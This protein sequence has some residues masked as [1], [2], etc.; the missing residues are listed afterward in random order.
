MVDAL[1]T[2]EDGIRGIGRR[3]FEDVVGEEELT[4]ADTAQLLFRRLK[5]GEV[6]E[7]RALSMGR[8]QAGYFDDPAKFADAARAVDG[9]ADVYM[10]IN[11]VHGEL[12]AR[13]N[14]R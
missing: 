14:N 10:T 11:P 2:R 7:V 5:P 13:S 6:I 8:V 1:R 4:L 9:R 3:R 12:L